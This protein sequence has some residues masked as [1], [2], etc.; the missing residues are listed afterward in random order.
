MFFSLLQI[1]FISR[2]LATQGIPDITV[3]LH[4]NCTQNPD[5]DM[6]TKKLTAAFDPASGARRVVRPRRLPGLILRVGVKRRT[7][8]FRY[9]AGGTYHRKPL[10]HFPA[11]ELGE[12]R[13]AA[14]KLIERADKGVPIDAPVPHPRSSDRAHAGRP[15]RPLRGHA[16]TGRQ[17]DQDAGRGDAAAAAKP[18]AVPVAARRPVL[19]RPTCAP[20][21][22][23][24][25][26]L[27]P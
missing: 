24:W 5:P 10:G 20:S 22:T 17:A 18:Q 14:R 15:A 13:D 7:W 19:A 11:M 21:A 3:W 1:G 26:R 23:P 12:A 8:Q 6:P 16:Q 27:T 25:S 9:H 4:P 2:P